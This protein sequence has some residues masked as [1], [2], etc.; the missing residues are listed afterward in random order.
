MAWTRPG[1]PEQ[2]QGV[3]QHWLSASECMSTSNEI[4][5]LLSRRDRKSVFGRVGAHAN[6]QDQRLCPKVGFN[7]AHIL[8]T[9]CLLAHWIFRSFVYL[10]GKV[11]DHLIIK[12][13]VWQIAKKQ[14]TNIFVLNILS[15]IECCPCFA[16]ERSSIIFGTDWR[17]QGLCTWGLPRYSP[18]LTGKYWALKAVLWWGRS[19]S[20]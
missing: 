18:N 4:S 16:Y 13:H 19:M 20:V 10:I 15:T 6:T 14:N 12:A 9:W 3:G 8:H 5:L 11:N 7:D 1:G 17:V 2:K